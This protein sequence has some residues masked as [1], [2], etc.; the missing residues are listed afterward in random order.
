VLLLVNVEIRWLV[1]DRR[2]IYKLKKKHNI[3]PA[4]VEEALFHSAPHIRSF[5]GVYHAYG[6]TGAGRYLFIV[7]V[8]LGK[9]RAR[10]ITARDMTLEERRLFRRIKGG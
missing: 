4:E 10:I 3:E 1:W 6:R 8:P 2:I 7:F 5:R 9:K